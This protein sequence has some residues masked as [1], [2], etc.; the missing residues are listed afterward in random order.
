MNATRLLTTLLTCSALGM[1]ALQVQSAHGD[2]SA[3]PGCESDYRVVTDLDWAPGYDGYS[4][5][6]AA[7]AAA[8]DSTLVQGDASSTDAEVVRESGDSSEVEVT[9]DSGGEVLALVQVEPQGEGYL[10]MTVKECR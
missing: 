6:E 10:P 5:P 9:D 8:A 7:A 2:T 1:V 3:P 4:S